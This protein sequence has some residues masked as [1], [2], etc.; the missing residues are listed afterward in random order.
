MP[1]VSN[2]LVLFLGTMAD[3][4]R[5]TILEFGPENL[6]PGD[7]L[8]TNDPSRAG[9]HFNDFCFIYPVFVDG[10]IVAYVNLRAHQIDVGGVI[11]AGFSAT[12]R[13]VYEDGLCIPPMLLFKGGE[14]VRSVF[15][16]IFDNS[17]MGEL[18]LPDVMTIHQQLMLGERLMLG[19]IDRYG[20]EAFLGTLRYACDSSAE[21]MR[22]AI[23]RI[24]DGD[25]TGEEL[26]DADGMDDTEEYWVRVTIRKRG[27]NLEADL[28]GTSRQARTC[29][30]GGILEAKTALVV[31]MTALLD[32]HI[33]FTSGLWRDID[34]VAPSGTIITS[35]PPEGGSMM[36]WE[37][38]E[39]LVSA[40][41]RALNP[42]LG[43]DG[44]GGDYGSPMVHNAQGVLPNGAPWAN[45]TH[46]GGE[47]GPWG[48]TR[49]GDG[50][51][52]TVIITLNNLDPATE[53]IEHEAPVV[54][55]RKEIVIDT[56]GPGTHR[57][58]AA[59]MKDSMWMTEANHFSSPFRFKNPTAAA[60][61]GE[62]GVSGAVWIFPA[63]VAAVRERGAPIGT[64][65]EVYSDSKPVAGVLD[66]SS[67]AVDPKGKYFYFASEPV[68]ETQPNSV[69]RY[70]TNGAGGWGNPLERDP[71]RVRDDVRDGYVSIEGARRDYGVVIVGDPEHDPE[72]LTV[73]AEETAR[74]RGAT[75]R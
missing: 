42:V 37:A 18:L 35:M 5:N 50:D 68:W 69:F 2:S 1:V 27:H 43:V 34:V 33:P 41:C 64:G 38:E 13:N 14:P 75:G 44:W 70:V 52:Y 63:D 57:G 58:G 45:V 17:R 16:L 56:G 40:V 4:A 59:I 71:E 23:E 8:I 73:D 3:A 60:N 65:T 22:E 28:S 62:P 47:H 29:I 54:I 67:K 30:N 46:C 53:V 21:L 6:G 25:Y 26:I 55:L 66:V 9:N 72:G 48:A 15:S 12:K 7:V 19:H 24:P 32:P 61:G 11:A 20:V 10:E 31:A 36:Y 49:H 39:A 51:S 74:L